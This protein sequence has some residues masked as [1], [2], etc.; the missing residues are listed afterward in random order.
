VISEK[1]FKN[2]EEKTDFEEPELIRKEKSV[3]KIYKIMERENIYDIFPTYDLQDEELTQDIIEV[4]KI[5]FW[6]ASA[7][8]ST[9]LWL[10][11]FLT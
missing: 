9:L 6:G 11:F 7:V 8:V 3:E 10:Y 5:L 2:Y 4:Y 1:E